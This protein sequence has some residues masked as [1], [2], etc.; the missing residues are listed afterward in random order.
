MLLLSSFFR[1]KELFKVKNGLTMSL[2]FFFVKITKN[3]DGR[4]TLKRREKKNR[5][6]PKV[7]TWHLPKGICSLSNSDSTHIFSIIGIFYFA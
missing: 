4:T 3:W 6:C 1:L 2:F 5:G 7:A